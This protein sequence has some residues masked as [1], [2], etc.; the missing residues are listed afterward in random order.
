MTHFAAALSL[1]CAVS[2]MDCRRAPVLSVL[3]GIR[4][5][6]NCTG[7]LPFCPLVAT[8]ESVDLT[9]SNIP[10]ILPVRNNPPVLERFI[11]GQA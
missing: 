11:G 7:I 1:C 10:V 8:Y 4:T 6:Q 3:S 2:S 5:T 9:T